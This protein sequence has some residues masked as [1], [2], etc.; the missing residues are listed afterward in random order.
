M[1][2]P[3]RAFSPDASALVRI[4]R[5][6]RMAPL[7]V[8]LLGLLGASPASAAGI[9]TWLEP[10]LT[11]E[12]DVFFHGATV[13]AQG[14]ALIATRGR[15]FE[16]IDTNGTQRLLSS[17]TT[18]GTTATSSYT[19]VP[20][21]PVSTNVKWRYLVHEYVSTTCTG[22]P[23]TTTK[24]FYVAQAE[25]F[26]DAALTIPKTIFAPGDTV[27]LRIRGY[28][29]VT[30]INITSWVRPSGTTAC[31]NTA[32]GDRPNSTSQGVIPMNG[33]GQVEY[34]PGVGG[35][36]W[37][38]IINYDNGG[39]CE[40][41][42]GSNTGQWEIR[43]SDSKDLT[44]R[45]TVQLKAFINTAGAG[46]CGD[47]TVGAGEQC[48]SG[49]ANGTASSCCSATCQFVTAATQ[50]RSSAG[51][52]DVAETC[53]GASAACPADGFVAVATTCRAS[54]GTCDVAEVCSGSGPACPADGFAS[55]ATQCRPSAGACDIAENCSGSAATCPVDGFSSAATQCRASAGACD[56][57][58]SCS[59]SAA[60]CPPDGFAS[61]ATQCRAS[62]GACDVAENC[63]GSAATCPADVL[64]PAATTCR[65]SAGD[66][67]VAE[68]CSGS[69]AAC[70]V[71]GFQ[72]AAT[73]CRASA[74]DCDVAE[75][76]SGSGATCPT[77]SFQSAATECRAS[78]GDC[79]VAENWS[80]SG[81]NCPTDSFESAAT[82]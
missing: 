52:C 68:A 45:N 4:F 3:I 19:V 39:P 70:P 16:V 59:G 78:A 65:A 18:G 60:T 36:G 12:R 46:T 13:Y 11:T 15:R 56:V 67:D 33:S 51:A 49:A 6:L 1:V 76:C 44:T 47:S 73:E 61:A 38:H 74:G 31:S 80:G 58:E 26:A 23:T 34:P 82:D 41:L 21:A 72:S 64:V 17:C 77:D 10:A 14:T 22:T 40:A 37:N 63:S 79:D 8:M 53:T 75:N 42:S 5:S 2:G 55:A 69:S 66:C 48:D 29:D 54:S 20:G 28:V 9:Q 27:H 81:A 71:D 25:T 35:D 43:L 32:G 24:E 57:A 62:A 7:A 50:C 30:N